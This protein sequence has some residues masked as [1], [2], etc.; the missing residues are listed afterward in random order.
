MIPT[1]AAATDI[2]AV[3]TMICGLLF[4]CA[5]SGVATVI[6]V[7]ENDSRACPFQGFMVINVFIC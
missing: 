7:D 3:E 4:T 6:G 2:I 5:I 1:A